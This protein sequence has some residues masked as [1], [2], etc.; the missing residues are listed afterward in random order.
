[1][2]QIRALIGLWTL[3]VVKTIEDYVRLVRR[4]T[5]ANTKRCA[6]NAHTHRQSVRLHR[7]PST[8]Q[9]NVDEGRAI[10]KQTAEP[11]TY[12][13]SRRAHEYVVLITDPRPCP[14]PCENNERG[15]EHRAVDQYLPIVHVP[16]PK[17]ERRHARTWQKRAKAAKLAVIHGE[18]DGTLGNR[19]SAGHAQ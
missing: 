11:L 4:I 1:M 6:H 17:N 13:F 10:S 14:T 18:G 15:K 7:D 8:K 9:T 19:N 16:F 2:R 5:P 12:R 3:T